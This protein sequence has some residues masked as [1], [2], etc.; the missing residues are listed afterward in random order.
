MNIVQHSTQGRLPDEMYGFGIPRD[1]QIHLKRCLVTA[2]FRKSHCDAITG[3][4]SQ[5]HSEDPVLA[6]A[7]FS[8]QKGLLHF[9]AVETVRLHLLESLMVG[10]ISAVGPEG[11]PLQ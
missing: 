10:V 7:G 8:G 4:G 11:P 5:L 1:C 2:A 9:E 6:L 3:H